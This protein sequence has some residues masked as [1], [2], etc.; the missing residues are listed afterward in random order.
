MGFMGVIHSD[1]IAH[2]E[3]SRGLSLRA[4]RGEHVSLTVIYSSKIDAD[5]SSFF[6]L[7]DM[8]LEMD[9]KDHLEYF[10]LAQAAPQSGLFS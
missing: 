4:P 1:T 8:S 5:F 7:P 9:T 10:Q 3:L 2:R 6:Y